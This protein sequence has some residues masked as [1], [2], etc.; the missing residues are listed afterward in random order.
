MQQSKPDKP[1]H[2]VI[3]FNVVEEFYWPMSWH[4]H[5]SCMSP[6]RMGNTQSSRK[7]VVSDFL[8]DLCVSKEV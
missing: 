8:T 4:Q 5:G 1:W 2:E 3:R 6:Y 7:T